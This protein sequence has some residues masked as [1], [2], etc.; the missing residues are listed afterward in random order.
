MENKKDLGYLWMSEQGCK[1]IAETIENSDF[2]ICKSKSFS[3]R[4]YPSLLT[5][6]SVLENTYFK[7][8]VRTPKT[9]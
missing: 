6:G 9:T 8:S 5:V 4:L 7:V 2:V 3:G 1:V